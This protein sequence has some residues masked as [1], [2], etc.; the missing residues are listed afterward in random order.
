L[1]RRVKEME[2][3]HG[4]NAKKEPEAVGGN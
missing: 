2:V 4:Y 3:K 1:K